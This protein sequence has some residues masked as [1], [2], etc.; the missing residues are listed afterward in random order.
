[1]L[2][3]NFLLVVENRLLQ[4][5]QLLLMYTTP[6]S[7]EPQTARWLRLHSAAPQQNSN[8]FGSAFGLHE[9]SHNAAYHQFF[10]SVL[11][12]LLQ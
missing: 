2:S 3:K 8:K 6:N 4:Y 11:S 12:C 10:S 7:P 1:M 5:L 9:C